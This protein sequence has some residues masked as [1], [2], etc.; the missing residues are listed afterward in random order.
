MAM[1]KHVW[2]LRQIERQT[3]QRLLLQGH[4]SQRISVYLQFFIVY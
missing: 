2:Q 4:M 1:I 3:E